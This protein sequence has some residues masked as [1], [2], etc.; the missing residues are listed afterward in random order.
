MSRRRVALRIR[1]SLSLDR[2]EL[3]SRRRAASGRTVVA[4]EARPPLLQLPEARPPSARQARRATNARIR[5][6]RED[7]LPRSAPAG[8][9]DRMR[10]ETPLDLERTLNPE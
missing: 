7:R 5:A 8:E 6:Q 10:T 3:W 2:R 1:D 4:P 9:T